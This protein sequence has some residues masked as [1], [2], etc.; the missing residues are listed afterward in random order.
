MRSTILFF[1]LAAAAIAVGCGSDDSDPPGSAAAGKPEGA[2]PAEAE[3][4]STVL[5]Q[6][7]LLRPGARGPRRD[8]HRRRQVMGTVN[9]KP[10]KY[11]YLCSVG[12][13]WQLGQHGTLVVK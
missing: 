1:G 2:K 9:L 12:G 10:G 13:H 3:P 11:F 4:P 5:K 8:N 6:A 7:L